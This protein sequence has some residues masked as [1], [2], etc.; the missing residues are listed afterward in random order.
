MK[1]LVE[2]WDINKVKPYENNPR[3]NEN[4]VDA[5]AESIKQFGFQQEIVVD[6][7]GVVIVGHTRLKAA[8]KLG[9]K[10]VPVRIAELSPEKTRAY[11]LADNKVGEESVWDNKKLLEELKNLDKDIFTGFD[12]SQL[13]D[14]VLDE[15]DNAPIEENKSGVTYS[16]DFSTQ[17]RETFEEVRDYIESVAEI[18]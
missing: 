4:A 14:D 18:E 15:A 11:R 5:V 7:N 12:E 13:F 6:K 3:I 16:L 9:L 10:T 1:Y 17:N 8:K 2:Q